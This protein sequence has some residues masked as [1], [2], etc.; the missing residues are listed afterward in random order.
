M[1]T[2]KVLV[3]FCLGVLLTHFLTGLDAALAQEEQKTGFLAGLEGDALLQDAAMIAALFKG[4]AAHTG[5]HRQRIAF[6]AVAADKAVPQAVKAVRGKIGSKE[7][8]AALFVVEVVL[9]NAVL[10]PA[11]GG[12]QAHL[13]ILVVHVHLMEAEFQIGEYGKMAHPARIVAQL[14]IPDLHGVVHGDEKLLLGVDLG[15]IGMIFDVAQAVTA[16]EMLLWLA[17]RL[18]GDAPV[19][20]GVLIPQV[21][22]VA[23]AVHGNAVGT[24][25]G[26]AMVFRSFVQQ[27][28][29]RR[30]VEYA[31]HILEADVVCPGNGD[32]YPIDDIFPV[33]IVKVPIT[34]KVTSA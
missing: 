17:H 5:L 12:V 26:D 9:D 1:Q 32:V 21:Y 16:G 34:H 23:G 19:V 3:G 29:A 11:A 22:V 6:G 4:A 10:I 18:P 31:V 13:E 7:L 14:H 20:A 25:P 15:V 30:V 24:E 28:S 8:I 2:G 33:L 27:V